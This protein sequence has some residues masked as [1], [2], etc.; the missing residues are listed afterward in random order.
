MVRGAQGRKE[1]KA[2]EILPLW[3]RHDATALEGGMGCGA[4]SQRF[5][6]RPLTR[7]TSLGAGHV[8]FRNDL[9]NSLLEDL[10]RLAS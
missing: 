5:G 3:E 4:G 8:G 9:P 10:C 1:L 2:G 7:L 6:Q